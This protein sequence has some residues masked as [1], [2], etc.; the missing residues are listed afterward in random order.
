MSRFVKAVILNSIY[1][2]NSIIQVNSRRGSA[3]TLL[4]HPETLKYIDISQI[5]PGIRIVKSTKITK[6]K[7]ISMR[8]NKFNE[9]GI[10]LVNSPNNKYYYS[11]LSENAVDQFMW[12]YIK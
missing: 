12:F 5:F 10:L 3:T 9:P 8:T 11:N 6:G 4:V 1:T 7:I 2:S